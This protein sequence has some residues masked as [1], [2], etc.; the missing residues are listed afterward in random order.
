MKTSLCSVL[1]SGEFDQTKVL[2]KDMFDKYDS[3]W[4]S[5]IQGVFLDDVG[6]GK[7]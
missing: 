1:P 7:A 4:T 3:T 5:D 2:N 6:N